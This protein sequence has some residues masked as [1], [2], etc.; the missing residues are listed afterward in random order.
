VALQS[1]RTVKSVTSAQER[2]AAVDTC[3]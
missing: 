2:D 1:L 3:D